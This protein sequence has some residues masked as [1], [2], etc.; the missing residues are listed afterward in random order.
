MFILFL[1]SI[2]SFAQTKEYIEKYGQWERIDTLSWFPEVLTI[3]TDDYF[4]WTSEGDP[5][6]IYTRYG[7]WSVINDTLILN[8]KLLLHDEYG[9]GKYLKKY[10]MYNSE[11][12]IFLQSSDKLY[13]LGIYTIVNKKRK[14]IDYTENKGKTL[15][16][17]YLF[18]FDRV[19]FTC[20]KFPR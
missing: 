13:L 3:G 6:T 18:F 15:D 11:K 7:K 5:G 2:K 4:V 1:C 20:P 17:K 14:F 19:K 8:C 9:S 12:Y 16:D 10:N